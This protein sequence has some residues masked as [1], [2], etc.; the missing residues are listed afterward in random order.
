MIQHLCRNLLL[1][2][3]GKRK[4][5][6]QGTAKGSGYEPRCSHL[7]SSMTRGLWLLDAPH[8][9]HWAAAVAPVHL[10]LC[11]ISAHNCSPGKDTSCRQKHDTWVEIHDWLQHLVGD[12]TDS[13]WEGDGGNSENRRRLEQTVCP[14]LGI[15]TGDRSSFSGWTPLQT[16]SWPTSSNSRHSHIP[17]LRGGRCWKGTRNGFSRRSELRCNFL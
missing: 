14:D 4:E 5:A 16:Q 8:V 13:A 3:T 6:S 10:S 9:R 1:W 2:N 15:S 7:F 11:N 12:G 17:W